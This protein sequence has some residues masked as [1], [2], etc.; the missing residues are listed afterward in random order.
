MSAA[1]KA[2]GIVE[3]T[4]ANWVKADRAGQLRGLSREQ[5]NADRMENIRLN[6]ELARV[7]MERDILHPTDDDLFAGTPAWEK[8]R[9]TS[10]KCS[11]EVRLDREEQAA[12][13]GVRAVPASGGER[14]GLSPAS[15]AKEEEDPHAQASVGDGPS[16]GDQRCM[17]VRRPAID[18]YQFLRDM[19]A[20][21]QPPAAAR[22]HTICR[23]ERP[24][25]AAANQDP[26]PKMSL[27]IE[28]PPPA[29]PARKAS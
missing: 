20:G 29:A 19:R 24:S 26:Y 5:L 22:A 23:Q 11:D 1:A 6:A 16:G 9:R 7:T 2:L 15:G 12:V 14:I 10:R 25:G 21:I 4:L 18:H 8:R 3:Q 13:A 27:R 17:P 28:Q